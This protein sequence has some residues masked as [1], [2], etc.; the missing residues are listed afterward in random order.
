MPVDR[1]QYPADDEAEEGSGDCSDL[2]DADSEPPTI[3]G[4]RIGEDGGRVGEQHR[5][6]D[7]LHHAP[8]NEPHRAGAG[9]EGVEDKGHGRD[10]EDHETEVVDANATIDVS[11]PAKTHDEYGGHQDVSHQH[12]EQ[13]ADVARLKWVQLDAGEDRG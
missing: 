11:E 12:P 9:D 6:S 5:A 2:V 8:S 13:V 4:K 3:R 10:G 7:R 1:S